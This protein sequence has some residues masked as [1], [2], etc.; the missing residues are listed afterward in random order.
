MKF[1]S[2]II[3]F[4]FVSILI[5][6]QQ[7]E[8]DFAFA[9][10]H[11][12]Y[13]DG[14]KVKD[15]VKEEAIVKF[16][17]LFSRQGYRSAQLN[18]CSIPVVK[19]ISELD[20]DGRFTDLISIEKKTYAENLW[21][22]KFYSTENLV[23]NFLVEAHNRI[24]KIALE[25]KKGKLSDN[26]PKYKAFLKA[27]LHYGKMELGRSNSIPRFHASCFAIPTATVNTYF[28]LLKKMDDVE[29]GK[30]K[31]EQLAA[32]CDMLKALSLQA[33]TQPLRKDETDKNV[34]QMDRFRNHVWWVGGNALAYRSLLPVAFMYKSI[35]MI[36]LLSDVCQKA[37]ST[38]SQNT[39]TTSFWTEG[40]TADGAGWGHGRQSLVWGYPIDG[41][42]NALAMLNMLKASPW[43]K[44]LS[45]ENVD[46]LMNF[47]RGSNWYYYKGFNLSGLDRT[48]M[49]YDV[50][51][52]PIRY[53]GMLNTLLSDW[54]DS[55][56]ASELSELKQLV[57]EGDDMNINMNL[58][59]DGVYT[60]TRWFFNND[61][62]MKK[63]DRYHIFVN[64]AS[65]RCDGLES[66][67]NVADEYNF[68]TDDGMTLFQR[69][70]LEYR[71]VFGAWDVSATPGVT[72]R[73]GMD[74]LKP[75]TNWRG[76]CSKFNFAGAA[77]SGGVNAVAGFIVEKM[78][79]SDKDNV[80]D[81]GTN[82]ISNPVLY[83]V[84]AHK[85]YFMLD[86]YFVA[87]GAGVTNLHPE[88]D[89][90]IRTTIDQTAWT[91]DVQIFCNG[92]SKPVSE[93]I[94]NFIENGKPVWVIQKNKFAYSILPEFTKNARFISESKKTDWIKMNKENKKLKNLPASVDIL[95]LWIDHGQQ[96]VNDTYGYVVFAGEKI[97]AEKMPFS[98]LRN[99]TL[100]QAVQSTDYKTTEVVFFQANSQLRAKNLVLSASAP[101]IILIESKANQQIL[102]VNDPQMD[103]NLKQIQI[104]LNGK[105]ILVD[106][107]KG[108][109]CGKPVTIKQ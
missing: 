32:V 23:A 48:G 20:E 29:S 13:A 35:P 6:A 33:W 50:Q 17:Q 54:K 78:N 46:A 31:D 49:R 41:T 14:Q 21:F 62:L 45:R 96:V 97:P 36:D 87:L 102:S 89:G 11:R 84:K 42:S 106:M 7:K 68:F 2:A 101:C 104:V 5:H 47:F 79:G 85:S 81:K 58:L 26:D 98:V 95:R 91:E 67:L 24:W 39:N 56:S 75:V 103:A 44:K 109:L 59:N 76:Y 93:G 57:R 73:D 83:G 94:Q 52:K 51:P 65:V 90:N 22:E 9:N 108:D 92:R 4:T 43:E 105:I 72:A 60:G 40:F 28:C 69:D 53:M 8:I 38:T 66:A 63:T 34:V 86:D 10:Y 100:I 30:N 12:Y 88:I 70:G 3:L 37:I 71:S 15:P 19:A 1:Y 55:F 77:T 18:A 82:N 25:I 74:K 107:P 27:I 99:D 16:R 80:N 61:D 64:M